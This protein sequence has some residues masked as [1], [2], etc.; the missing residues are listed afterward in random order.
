M[1]TM[2]PGPEDPARTSPYPGE[3]SASQGGGGR[4]HWA[5]PPGDRTE[6][7]SVGTGQLGGRRSLESAHV[8]TCSRGSGPSTSGLKEEKAWGGR[9]VP[10]FGREAGLPSGQSG[11]S[12]VTSHPGQGFWNQ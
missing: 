6:K 10:A 1:A 12:P 7:T 5:R 2:P 3:S 11:S 4:G 8:Q 9:E